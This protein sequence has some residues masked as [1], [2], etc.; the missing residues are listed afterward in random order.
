VQR[1][2]L[3]IYN[4]R[5]P[6]RGLQLSLYKTVSAACLSLTRWS[7]F[8]FLW[9]PWPAGTIPDAKWIV[10]AIV[11]TD[12][13]VSRSLLQFV[14]VRTASL[15]KYDEQIQPKLRQ[16][17]A[18]RNDLQFRVDKASVQLDVLA[19]SAVNV[20]GATPREPG[21]KVGMVASDRDSATVTGTGVVQKPSDGRSRPNSAAGEAGKMAVQGQEAAAKLEA[22]QKLEAAGGGPSRVVD[23]SSSVSFLVPHH[24]RA[25]AVA[26]I[27]SVVAATQDDISRCIALA[28]SNRGVLLGMLKQWAE[29]QQAATS[30]TADVV[31]QCC[32]ESFCVV[33][34]SLGLWCSCSS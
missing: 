24:K 3:L 28:E 18:Y 25:S 6:N 31:S 26:N 7:T 12:A 34:L 14:V 30:Q 32:A 13:V 23:G 5:L 20:T 1:K 15:S 27:M 17:E 16:L 22:S 33:E 11:Q 8:H 21:V 10:D 29:A 4:I 19:V 2:T 9:S